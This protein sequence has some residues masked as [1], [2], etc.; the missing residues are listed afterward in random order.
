MILTDEQIKI[1]INAV[2]VAV[3]QVRGNEQQDLLEV[4][5]LLAWEVGE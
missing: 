4:R 3:D 1:L 2:D 5:A